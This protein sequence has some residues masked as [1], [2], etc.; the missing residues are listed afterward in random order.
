VNDDDVIYQQAMAA[1]RAR[2]C[3]HHLIRDP[4]TQ[5]FAPAAHQGLSPGR[6]ST[7]R[8]GAWTTTWA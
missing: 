4:E 7:S 3:G 5:E 1:A 6:W 2:R 8:C